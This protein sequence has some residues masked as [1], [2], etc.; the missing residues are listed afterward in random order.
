MSKPAL[1]LDRDGVIIDDVPYLS[2]ADGVLL[3]SSIADF[4]AYFRQKGFWVFVVTNQSGVG[5]GKIQPNELD[6]I[7]ERM[8]S[9]LLREHE[10]AAID[11]NFHCPHHPKADLIEYRKL[12]DCR[13]PKPGLLSMACEQFDVDLGKSIMIGDRESDIAAG[14][15]LG[16]DSYQIHAASSEFSA[17]AHAKAVFPSVAELFQYAKKCL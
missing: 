8:R 10:H 5:R 6:D 14:N 1:F 2:D 9:L 3:K 12:C 11:A 13:K 7:H 17:S 16:V 15:A 4:L